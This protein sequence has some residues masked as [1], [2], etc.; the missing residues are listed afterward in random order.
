MDNKESRRAMLK[1]RCRN[2]TI[3]ELHKLARELRLQLIKAKMKK[4]D[5]AQPILP[6]R[7]NIAI[8]QT[9]INQKQGNY[10]GKR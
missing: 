6:L 10:H 7:R 1:E 2:L 4:D 3:Q 8:V 9:F 5:K